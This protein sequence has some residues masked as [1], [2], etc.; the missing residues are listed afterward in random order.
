MIEKPR[1]SVP[2]PIFNDFLY[3]ILYNSS[4]A[5]KRELHGRYLKAAMSEKSARL[6]IQNA[7]EEDKKYILGK[8]G[9]K[10]FWCFCKDDFKQEYL[11]D[12]LKKFNEDR[13]VSALKDILE[14]GIFVTGDREFLRLM[15]LMSSAIHQPSFYFDLEMQRQGLNLKKWRKRYMTPGD[16]QMRSIDEGASDVARTLLAGSVAID[17]VKSTIGISPSQMKILLYLYTQ[18]HIFMSEHHLKQFFTGYIRGAELRTG[19][20]HL[21]K[22]GFIEGEKKG[23]DWSYTISS[24]GTKTV[25]EY[26][27][28]VFSKMNF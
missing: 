18:P 14:T 8:L 26:F 3:T 28:I 7:S 6:F 23:S 22:E 4:Y 27:K 10:F 20:R 16:L 2:D 15:G 25:S 12:I 19:V 21:F 5:Q 1:R 24:K 9:Y 17:Y 13:K 11:S